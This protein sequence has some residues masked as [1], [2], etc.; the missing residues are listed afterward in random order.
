MLEALARLPLLWFIFCLITIMGSLA[1]IRGKLHYNGR[2]ANKSDANMAGYF[3][4]VCAVLPVL[5]LFGLYLA[6]F[7]PLFAKVLEADLTSSETSWTPEQIGQLYDQ[8][9]YLLSQRQMPA[10]GSPF[11]DAWVAYYAQLKGGARLAMAGLSM[12]SAYAVYQLG[13]RWLARGLNITK[14]MDRLIHTGLFACAALAVL[15][16]VGIVTSLIYETGRFFLHENGPQINDFLFGL[17]WDT[18]S[19]QS[20]GILPLLTG[21]V[22][23]GLIA[24][25]VA[26]PVGLMCAIYLSE[27]ATPRL[28]ETV[29]PIL[30]I[31]AGIPTVVYGFF[32]AILVAP[33]VR[34]ASQ[35]VNQLPFIPDTLLAAQPV[36]ALAAGLV[37]GIMIIPLM[38]SLSDDILRTIPQTLRDGALALGS[39]Q[40]ET[41]R[42]IVL[43][44]ALPGVLAALL[45][46]ASRAI[47]ET[48]IVVMAAG[49]RTLIS[50][51]PTSDMTTVTHQIVTLLTGDTS[52]DSA[53][54][55]SAFALGFALFGVT[56]I[57]NLIALRVVRNYRVRYV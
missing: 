17:N 45:L 5:P 53:R 15:I 4:A 2:R 20:F 22:L 31:L 7:E 1:F 41:I 51:D 9:R 48:M 8:I 27:Y 24:L 40:A 55:L 46:S 35:W 44:A 57:F 32:A 26:V 49:G 13:R 23:I 3:L 38:S 43:P 33:L 47:G 10:S 16:T 37:M 34:S 6:G 29:K 19:G 50:L 11:L 30:E 14:M 36:N 39:T 21:T 54:T 25:L 12:L 52:F 28:R 42:Q 18:Q 56:L